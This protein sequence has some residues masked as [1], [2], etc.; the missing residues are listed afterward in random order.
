MFLRGQHDFKI[1]LPLYFLQSDWLI[2]SFR[3]NLKTISYPLSL[4]GFVGRPWDF[5]IRTEADGRESS[6]TSKSP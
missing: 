6:R 3:S 1:R 5:G 4:W 2:Q